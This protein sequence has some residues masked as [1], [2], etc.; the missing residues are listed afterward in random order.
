MDDCIRRHEYMMNDKQC[1]C[2]RAIKEAAIGDG[3]SG[4][5]RLE[6]GQCSCTTNIYSW[7]PACP[8]DYFSTGYVCDNSVIYMCWNAV[9]PRVVGIVDSNTETCVVDSR[10]TAIHF[11]DDFRTN[12]IIAGGQCGN[13]CRTGTCPNGGTVTQRIYVDAPTVTSETMTDV[14]YSDTYG[15]LYSRSSSSVVDGWDLTISD[16][17]TTGGSRPLDIADYNYVCPPS[18]DVQ[19]DEE[20]VGE[21]NYQEP[22]CKISYQA[23]NSPGD[24][25]YDKVNRQVTL[26]TGYYGGSVQECQTEVRIRDSIPPTISC[27]GNIVVTVAA[28]QCSA[29]VTYTNPIFNDNCPGASL[30][31]MQGLASG[32]NFPI[33]TTTVRYN[34][35]DRGLNPATCSFQVQVNGVVPPPVLSCPTSISTQAAIGQCDAVVNYDVT[36]TPGCSGREVTQERQQGLASGSR[37][38]RGVTTVAFRAVGVNPAT[39]PAT[40]SF[41]VTVTVQAPTITCP[42]N[43]N[44]GY[45]DRQVT[46]QTATA[47]G[48]GVSVLR[49]TGLPRGSSFPLGATSISFTATDS[50][51]NS[52][53]CTFA[54]YV[55]NPEPPTL[56]S[57]PASRTVKACEAVVTYETPTAVSECGASLTPLM[58]SGLASGSKFPIGTTS[59]IYR[60]TDSSSGTDAT[61]AFDIT[62]TPPAA[63]AITCPAPIS[64]TYCQ[65]AVAYV[66]PMGTNECRATLTPTINGPLSGSTF[67]FGATTSVT[68][69][70]TD[71]STNTATSCTMAVTVA[72][73]KP[74]AITCPADSTVTV[75]NQRVSYTPPSSTSECGAALTP[76]FQSGIQS[77]ALFPVG[78]TRNSF[79]VLDPNS[80]LG[81]SC[82]FQVTVVD[83]RPPQVTCSMT[84][85]CE[86]ANKGCAFQVAYSTT[87]DCN[88][89]ISGPVTVSSAHVTS[90]CLP[91]NIPVTSTTQT[92]LYKNADYKCPQGKNSLRV[93]P[94]ATFVVQVRDASGNTAR[95][96]AVVVVDLKAK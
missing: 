36:S 23:R 50:V 75:C 80:G 32:S 57:C 76:A 67:P 46:Y 21:I 54:I 9:P 78:T 4:T 77:G 16:L 96:D 10:L 26:F 28:N 81:G 58:E 31:L 7:G 20:C 3:P 52:A 14:T 39:T 40:C 13:V 86:K 48:C 43:I 37:F 22:S 61:C 64:V 56:F 60:A 24:M 45:C 59:V 19:V 74:P 73:P 2:P 55:A 84:T 72:N 88:G 93:P 90:V 53:S 51:L 33:G 70:A 29:A 71:S 66:T 27:P 68:F 15:C 85:V 41:Q 79:R 8:S 89:V 38:P 44:V 87:D 1:R 92:I 82:S 91:T 12:N 5:C 42:T 11:C 83:D 49:T 18:I 94:T 25:Y 95:C 17:Q 30:T 69:T 35:R 65:A 63:P 6:F 62:V 47:V 34:V